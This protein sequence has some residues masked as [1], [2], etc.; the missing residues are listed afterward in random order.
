MH[1]DQ[2]V[3]LNGMACLVCRGDTIIVESIGV[4]LSV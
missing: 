2:R 3:R 1:C 4:C